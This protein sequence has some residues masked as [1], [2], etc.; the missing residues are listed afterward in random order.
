MIKMDEV[1]VS[2]NDFEKA[3]YKAATGA[4]TE[5][6]FAVNTDDNTCWDVLVNISKVAMARLKGEM[7]VND[8]MVVCDGEKKFTV[9][10]KTVL[11]R[12]DLVIGWHSWLV[13]DFAA[14]MSWDENRDP[15]VTV[16][17]EDLRFSR[18]RV[19]KSSQDSIKITSAVNGMATAAINGSVVIEPLEKILGAAAIW[20]L[21]KA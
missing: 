12:S 17:A 18:T 7:V 10:G 14:W 5:E 16:V 8:V 11:H 1:K 13:R 2:S 3:V 15:V 9:N 6:L 21:N 19:W 4:V 20:G